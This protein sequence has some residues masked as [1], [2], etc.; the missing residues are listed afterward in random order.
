MYELGDAHLSQDEQ[1]RILVA[2]K[3]EADRLR[4][5]PV[6]VGLRP[7]GGSPACPQCD[8]VGAAPAGAWLAGAEKS[9][10]LYKLGPLL[11]LHV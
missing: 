9:S 10:P 1:D 8:H 2:L 11:R 4:N 3:G 7:F 6:D 5:I